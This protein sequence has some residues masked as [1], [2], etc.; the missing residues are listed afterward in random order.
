MMVTT[1]YATVQ[2]VIAAY[3]GQFDEST[4]K[5]SCA[6]M[7][8]RHCPGPFMQVVH[9]HGIGGSEQHP[10]LVVVQVVRCLYQVHKCFHGD[11]GSQF[12]LF[13]QKMFAWGDLLQA[14]TLFNS[15]L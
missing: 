6:I 3:V 2:A 8:L 15:Q 4:N 7:C 11:K 1:A 14:N 10:Q 13:R 12:C 9:H 5:H